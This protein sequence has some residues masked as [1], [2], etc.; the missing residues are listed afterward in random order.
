MTRGKKVHPLSAVQKTNSN[1]L[2]TVVNNKLVRNVQ[3]QHNNTNSGSQ[4]NI[5]RL[6]F[7]YDTSSN[8]KISPSQSE[9]RI[10]EI[11]TGLSK[12]FMKNKSGSEGHNHSFSHH[13]VTPSSEQHSFNFDI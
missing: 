4:S 10:Y 13:G 1:N 7:E 8:I 6:L 9:E 11:G 2:Y 12:T 5:D 3:G